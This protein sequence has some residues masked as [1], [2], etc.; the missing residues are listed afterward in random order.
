MKPL[1]ATVSLA[2]LVLVPASAPAAKAPAA[3]R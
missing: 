1:F 2:A 3:Q